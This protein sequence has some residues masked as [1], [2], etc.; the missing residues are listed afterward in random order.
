ML[1]SPQKD[2][3]PGANKKY[4][5]TSFIKLVDLIRDQKVHYKDFRKFQGGILLS[6]DIFGA[7]GANYGTYFINRFPELVTIL[8]ALFQETNY[9]GHEVITYYTLNR[10]SFFVK[11]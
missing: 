6:K 7:M 1:K 3:V 5:T 4:K 8:Y 2:R 11:W 10:N 9:H